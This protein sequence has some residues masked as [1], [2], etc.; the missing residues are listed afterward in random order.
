MNIY[1]NIPTNSK[2]KVPVLRSVDMAVSACGASERIP[3]SQTFC[4]NFVGKETRGTVSILRGVPH[5]I[6]ITVFGNCTQVIASL[7][8]AFQQEVIEEPKFFD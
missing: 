8:E 2:K 1:V 3:N 7:W 5:V 6:Q 4:Y